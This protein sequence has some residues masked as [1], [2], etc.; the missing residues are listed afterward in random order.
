[1][2]FEFIT[3]KFVYSDTV[4]VFPTESFAV[5][6]V[7]QSS[8]HVEWAWH[9]SS[10]MRD[11][12]IRYTPTD[13]FETFPFPSDCQPPDEVS[14]VVLQ[15][16]GR[17]Y[18][19]FRDQAMRER[20][21]SLTQTYNR[22]HDPADTAQDIA[23]LRTLHCQV[24]LSVAAAYGWNDLDLDHGFHET[25]QGLRYT[26]SESARREVLDR[27]LTLNH[28]RHAEEVSAGLHHKKSRKRSL[29]KNKLGKNAAQGGL[30]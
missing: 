4:I 19:D 7:L 10:T 26:I 11:A 5:F 28:Q 2:F 25:K 29:S 1:V 21:M 22:F 9:R 14:N 24:D 13:C 23:E 3:P 15:D 16:I 12:G 8:L 20:G 27:L 30:Y 6:S 18:A 17:K